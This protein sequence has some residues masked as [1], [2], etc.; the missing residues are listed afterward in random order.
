MIKKYVLE[1]KKIILGIILSPF[2]MYVFNILVAFIFNIGTY[3][4]TY[5]RYVYS[6]FVC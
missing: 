5:L 1:N 3:F 4:G 2:A 6:S